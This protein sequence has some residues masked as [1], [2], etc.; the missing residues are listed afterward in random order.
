MPIS[1]NRATTLRLSRSRIRYAVWG[2]APTALRRLFKRRLVYVAAGERG[3]NMF[4][5]KTKYP[6]SWPQSPRVF[7]AGHGYSRGRIYAIGPV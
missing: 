3:F 5:A 1:T 6:Q 2:K 7:K 4:G